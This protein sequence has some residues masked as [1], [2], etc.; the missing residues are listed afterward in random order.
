MVPSAVDTPQLPPLQWEALAELSLSAMYF[1]EQ[2][3]EEV[4]QLSTTPVW[5]FPVAASRS[6]ILEEVIP[7]RNEEAAP[8][9]PSADFS[10]PTS[11][12]PAARP[13]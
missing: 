10:A 12:P 11:P 3:V 1:P 13:P 8:A 4:P 6:P 2:E 7:V 5:M 9:S